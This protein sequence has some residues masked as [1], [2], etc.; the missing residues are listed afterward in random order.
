M[1]Q[2]LDVLLTT[3]Q[4]KENYERVNHANAFELIPSA[5]GATYEEI[6]DGKPVLF[7]AIK[8]LAEYDTDPEYSIIN[9][10]SFGKAQSF[11]NRALLQEAKNNDFEV[12]S[13]SCIRD[14]DAVDFKS[15]LIVNVL[16][17][18]NGLTLSDIQRSNIDKAI[19]TLMG[20]GVRKTLPREN[21]FSQPNFT[22]QKPNASGKVEFNEVPTNISN[23]TIENKAQSNN[24]FNN[25]PNNTT[26]S[27]SKWDDMEDFIDE[28]SPSA[29]HRN[30]N[31]EDDY[32][33]KSLRP[34][35]TSSSQQVGPQN[36]H[37]AVAPSNNVP[38]G[39]QTATVTKR[40]NPNFKSK[41]NGLSLNTLRSALNAAANVP[42]IEEP[43]VKIEEPVVNNADNINVKANN[44]ENNN[45][46]IL[47]NN[48]TNNQTESSGKINNYNEQAV[49]S[50]EIENNNIGNKVIV[51]ES[52][53][54]HNAVPERYYV[55][56]VNINTSGID[57]QK[58]AYDN[59]TLD[60]PFLNS[61]DHYVPESDVK[62][63]E[64]DWPIYEIYEEDEFIQTTSSKDRIK[65]AFSQ[66]MRYFTENEHGNLVRVIKAQDD[67]EIDNFIKKIDTYID[68]YIKLPTEDLPYLRDKVY[69][70]LFSYYVLT[71]AIQDKAVS[72]IRILAPDNIN[73]KVHGDHYTAKGLQFLD[74]MDYMRFIETLLIRNRVDTSNPIL[75]FTDKDFHPDYILRFNVCLPSIN[76][77][78]LPYLHIRKVPKKKTTLA[79][80]IDAKMLDEKIALY[81]LDKVI[82]SRG[83]VF[84]GPS[85][86]G[87]TTLMNAL[88]DYIPK[89]KSILCIQESEELFSNVHPNAYFQH[90]LKDKYGNTIIGLSELGQNGLLCDSGYFI[91]GEC[92]GK[93]VRDL[94]R[95][96]NTGHKCWCS[97]HAQNTRETIPRLADYVKYG[98]DYTLQEATRMLKDLEVIIYIQGFKV[99]EISEIVGY[100][101]EKHLMIYKSIYKRD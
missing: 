2:I 80:L 86:S 52:N 12:L 85:A 48:Y 41:K 35:I 78:G 89:E 42:K 46:N 59:A 15:G 47:D 3:R 97:V 66:I 8:F 65:Q 30:N 64:Q 37:N 60:K 11:V 101:D 6:S 33:N 36:N 10:K 96:S 75:V 5:K 31:T 14:A 67:I 81:L 17:D 79:D 50:K 26:N 62:K 76:S 74:E 58:E 95:A 38:N 23:N 57:K 28:S 29:L 51:D 63:L 100:D 77:T 21:R 68:S 73:V 61:I 27:N 24:N 45:T 92:K 49:V 1:L 40:I 34:A 43:V 16:I 7:L 19:K 70:A 99:T 93:E 54:Y 55:R 87:K 4:E 98:A 90:M 9:E 44:M 25:N 91:I 72:D 83:I 20:Q 18:N 71:P 13:V 82:N 53:Y 84:A 32:N 39:Q 94:L 88:V 56:D 22:S 69:R